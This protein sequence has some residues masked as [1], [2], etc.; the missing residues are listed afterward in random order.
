[1]SDENWGRW[2]GL[3]AGR[4]NVWTRAAFWMIPEAAAPVVFRAAA[5]SG[6]SDW[7]GAIKKIETRFGHLADVV[8]M[9]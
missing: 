5:S 8:F 1:M 9:D 6:D 2:M 7:L 3:G 4:G